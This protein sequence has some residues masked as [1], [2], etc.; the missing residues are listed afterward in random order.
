M[1]RRCGGEPMTTASYEDTSSTHLVLCGVGAFDQ[2][3]RLA[4]KNQTHP[5]FSALLG[6]AKTPVLGVCLGM[7]MLGEGSEEGVL[8]GLRWIPARCRHLGGMGMGV[9]PHVG[10]ETLN[11]L[12]PDPLLAG[13]DEGARFYF[14]H[15]YGMDG[16]PRN[17]CSPPPPGALPLRRWC[18]RGMP[19]E[20]SFT[21]KRA[22]GTA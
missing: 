21:L 22:C 4:R 12:K 11:I 8:P 13:L 17:T 18:G 10:W 2:G 5:D 20:C 6:E 15:S 3:I 7:Q 19:G 1:V 9:V 16:V 14:S